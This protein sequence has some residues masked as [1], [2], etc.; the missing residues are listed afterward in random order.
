MKIHWEKK[1]F[2]QKLLP[3]VDVERFASKTR[4][5][6]GSMAASFLKRREGG[7][8]DGHK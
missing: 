8:G 5:G 2:R 4:R 7:I 6:G 3:Q 1:K